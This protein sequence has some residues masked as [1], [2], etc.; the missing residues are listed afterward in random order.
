MTMTLPEILI[1]SDEGFAPYGALIRH[2]GG[3]GRSYADL[4]TADMA[5][6]TRPRLWTVHR[7]PDPGGV[8]L[9]GL[10]RHPL[11]AQSFLPLGAVTLLAAV[12][13]TL[14][15]GG[16]DLAAMQAFILP[17]GTGISYRR[18]TWHHGLI[19]LDAPCDIA[20][21]MGCKSADEDTEL[22]VLPERIDFPA[23]DI[24]RR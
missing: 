21:F 9:T 23:G 1:A 10:E 14:P 4:A 2:A 13:P 18:G 7:A 19:S 20:V 16:P 17:P 12:C 3:A 11:S 24:P 5:S 6:E 8:A 15:D 22:F